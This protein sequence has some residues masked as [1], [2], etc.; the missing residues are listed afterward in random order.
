MTLSLRS[1]SFS[2]SN[3]LSTHPHT[4]GCAVLLLLSPIQIINRCFVRI[5]RSLTN[6]DANSRVS[7][8]IYILFGTVGLS[9]LLNT[10]SAVSRYN[11][12]YKQYRSTGVKVT[13]SDAFYRSQ[14][15]LYLNGFVLYL[16]LVLSLLVRLHEGYAAREQLAREAERKRVD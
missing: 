4:Q 3:I 13:C 14:R 1:V 10:V 7:R 9:V 5:L 11:S 6:F 8:P 2:H 15:D 12:A 16:T